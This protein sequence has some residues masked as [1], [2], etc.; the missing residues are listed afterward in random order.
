VITDLYLVLVSECSYF[1]LSICIELH[2]VVLI[3]S[4]YIEDGIRWYLPIWLS[5]H[6]ETQMVIFIETNLN[7]DSPYVM[8]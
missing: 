3:V 2:T 7:V 1:S 8:S 4:I 5:E 6:R